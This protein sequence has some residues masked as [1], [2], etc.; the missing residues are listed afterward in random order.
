LDESRRPDIH[1]FQAHPNRGAAFSAAFGFCPTEEAAFAAQSRGRAGRGRGIRVESGAVNLL[2]KF[3]ETAL[4]VLPVMGL[5]LALGLLA[6]PAGAGGPWWLGRF[7]VGGAL[8][9]L[10]L[11]VFLLGVDLGIR[12]MGERCGAALTAK[13]SLALL[14]GAAFVVGLVVTAAEPDIQVFGDQVRGVFPAVRKGALTF[15]IA[16]GV[17]LFMA[18]GMLRTTLGIPL[19]AVLAASYAALFLLAAFAPAPFVGVAFDSG[20]ATTGPMTVPFILALGIGVAAVRARGDRDG[21]FGLTGIASVGPV[22]AVL[23]YSLLNANVAAPHA[24]SAEVESHAEFAESLFSE[25][26]SGEAD[27]PPVETHAESAENAE[28]FGGASSPSEPKPESVVC[29]SGTSRAMPAK[30]SEKSVRR[31]LRRTVVAS[32]DWRE[33][34][35]DDVIHDLRDFSLAGDPDDPS[36]AGGVGFSVFLGDIEDRDHKDLFGPG[37]WCGR[38]KIPP[39]TMH[40]IDIRLDALLDRIEKE[41]G[42]AW[43]IED[44]RVVLSRKVRPSGSWLSRLAGNWRDG[45]RRMFRRSGSAGSGDPFGSFPAE[46]A[47]WEEP[48]RTLTADSFR[49]ELAEGEPLEVQIGVG[50]VSAAIPASGERARRVLDAIAAADDVPPPSDLVENRSPVFFTQRKED[51]EASPF[52]SEPRVFSV[53]FDTGRSPSNADDLFF[54]E[55]PDCKTVVRVRGVAPLFDEAVAEARAGEKRVRETLGGIVLETV[56]LQDASLPEVLAFFEASTKKSAG[57]DGAAIPFSFDEEAWRWSSP[58]DGP[59]LTIRAESVAL[60]NELALVADI[61]GVR[62]R[63]VGGGVRC[64]PRVFEDGVSLVA[65]PH[66]MPRPHAAATPEPIQHSAFSI[67][68]SSFFSS[69]AEAFPEALRESLSSIAPLFGL[70]LVFQFAL[71]KMTLRQ[72]LRIS[73]GFVWALIGLAVFLTGVNGGFMQAGRILGAALGGAAAAGGAGPWALLVGT[74]LA[75]GAVIVCAEPAVWVLSEQVEEAS[76]GAIRRRTLLFFLSLGTALAIGLAMWRAVAGFPLWRLLLPGYALALLLLARTPQP[77]AGIAFDSGG[78]AS[79]PLTSTFVLSFTLGA[80]S[81]GGGGSDSFGV[82]ALVAMMPLAAIQLMGILVDRKRRRAGAAAGGGA[83]APR[84][85]APA[86][87]PATK[88]ETP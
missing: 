21:G 52:D 77:F 54:W 15:S 80:A 16:G 69:F 68:H 46:S 60:T 40:A 61:A 13:R 31:K 42:F 35:I 75:F 48:L 11:T 73:I 51:P 87:D 44:G 62:W 72:A 22:A 59:R 32:V 79:G 78:V 29:A 28:L 30:E 41:R 1:F 37:T 2:E 45:F 20:G 4:S 9:V 25:G 88:G 81:A 12:P 56:D 6:V 74:G 14:L 70:F 3:R 76:G 50:G 34:D 36:G 5:V 24:E 47:A 64:I 86:P 23:V 65:D 8:L 39:F 67:Q 17:G 26:G 85:A 33:A 38:A 49:R 53:F 55:N 82:I 57:E 63:I 84:P 27:P 83:P 19:K 66:P 71:L 58:D 18:L 43:R 7:L 10:G